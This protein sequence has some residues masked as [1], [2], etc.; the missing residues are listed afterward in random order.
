MPKPLIRGSAAVLF[1]SGVVLAG[2]AVACVSST[3]RAQHR[4]SV[5]FMYLWFA[6]LAFFAGW[7]TQTQASIRD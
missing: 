4:V 7:V 6:L 1:L 5:T 3:I 2:L